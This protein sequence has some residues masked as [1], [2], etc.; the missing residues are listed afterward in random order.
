MSNQ[1]LQKI[2]GENFPP[3]M[4]LSKFGEMRAK[5]LPAPTPI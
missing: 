1:L 2:S 5:Y 4:L 3:K